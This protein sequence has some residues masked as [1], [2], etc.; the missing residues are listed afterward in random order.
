PAETAAANKPACADH[1]L[2]GRVFSIGEAGLEYCRSV[3]C[4]ESSGTSKS[5]IINNLTGCAGVLLQQ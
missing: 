5:L 4:L 3:R 2:W 1:L